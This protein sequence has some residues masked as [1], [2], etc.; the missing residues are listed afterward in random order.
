[1][2]RRGNWGQKG[3]GD[4]LK[5]TL[6]VAGPPQKEENK[7]SLVPLGEI[8]FEERWSMLCPDLSRTDSGTFPFPMESLL[9]LEK[10]FID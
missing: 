5:F 1:M 6:D 8:D 3:E 10:G 7:P 9:L 4:L 2:N